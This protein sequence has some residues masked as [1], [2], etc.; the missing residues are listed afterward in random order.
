MW[1]RMLCE[2]TIELGRGPIFHVEVKFTLERFVFT[3][4]VVPYVLS[5]IWMN[6]SLE[7]HWLLIPM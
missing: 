1:W 3:Y 5:L 2:S 6:I 4:D 7:Y